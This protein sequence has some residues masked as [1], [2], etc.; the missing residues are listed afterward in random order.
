ML[1]D[2]VWDAD[3]KGIKVKIKPFGPS[4]PLL[5]ELGQQMLADNAKPRIGFS[6][7]ILFT[8]SGRKVE[9]I[10]RVLSC[11]LVFNPARGGAFLRALNSL[12]A[13][14]VFPMTEEVKTQSGAKAPIVQ[15]PGNLASQLQAD[16]D[17]MRTFLQVQQERQALAEE[18]E[19]ARAVRV[20]M[21]GYLLESA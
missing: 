9:K 17:Q 8:S 19:K 3:A 15:Q 18:A 14:G 4:G 6:A 16:A 11:D 7:D 10:L 2:P 21:C 20:Q 12:Q 13:Q 5:T 1:H